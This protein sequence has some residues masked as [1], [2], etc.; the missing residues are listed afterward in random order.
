M[1]RRSIHSVLLL[2]MLLFPHAPVSAQNVTLDEGAFSVSLADGATGT[3]TFTIRQAGAGPDARVIAQAKI[4]WTLPSGTRTVVPLLE[5]RGGGL[6]AYQVEV[7]GDTREEIYVRA[8]GRRFVAN[9]RSD[10]GEQQ[11]EFRAR[12]G[13]VLLERGVAHQY[14]VPARGVLAVLAAGLD[15][16]PIPV[17]TPLAGE[18]NPFELSMGDVETLRIGGQP[19]EAHHLSLVNGDDRREVW[20]DQEGRVLRVEVPASGYVAE[21]QAPPRG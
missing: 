21:R 4:E 15:L 17:L 20:F 16:G 10:E 9:V 7:S 18:L 6:Y 3:E 1:F 13:S 12:P 8:E 2:A 14:F 19:I 5:A 11:R